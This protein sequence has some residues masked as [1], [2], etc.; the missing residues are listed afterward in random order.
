MKNSGTNIRKDY[1]IGTLQYNW[2]M[3][4]CVIY[5]CLEWSCLLWLARVRVLTN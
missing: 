4:M 1:G 2:P 3:F 5:C